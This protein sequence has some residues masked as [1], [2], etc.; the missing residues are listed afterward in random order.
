[1]ENVN[2]EV[3]ESL[4]Y[5]L[6]G[7]IS[8]WI[9][10]ALTSYPKQSQFE[11][12][13][14]ALVFTAIIRGILEVFSLI[15]NTIQNDLW[16]ENS[17]FLISII[18]SFV[19][20]LILSWLSNNDKFHKLLRYLKITKETSYAS[21]WFSA[22]S[23]GTTYVVLHLKDQRRIYGWPRE[24]PTEPDHGHFLLQNASW[25]EEGNKEIPLSDVDSILIDSS[26][27]ELVEF[28]K[29]TKE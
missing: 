18:L 5:L 21:E 8:A 3:I 15:F 19:L 6:P 17:D 20:G 12:V 2:L 7:F 1:M 25:L 11:R 22:F 29:L 26:N 9:F 13:I 23:S 27:V 24:W 4:K 16:F 14:Q 10:Y 28:V